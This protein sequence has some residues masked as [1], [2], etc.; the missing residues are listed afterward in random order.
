[1]NVCEE[2]GGGWGWGLGWEEEEFSTQLLRDCT[3]VVR[4]T[5]VSLIEQFVL[6][7]FSMHLSCK[8]ILTLEY[9]STVRT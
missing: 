3:S 9:P 6:Y 7:L 4:H 5:I 2:G 8:K 1:M